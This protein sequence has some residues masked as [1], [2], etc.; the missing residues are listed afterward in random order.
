MILNKKGKE[1]TS[2]TFS[3]LGYPLD[4]HIHPYLILAIISAVAPSPRFEPDARSNFWLGLAI[5]LALL[6][7]AW[8]DWGMM[9][10]PL[11]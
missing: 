2:R 1:L 3:L 6:F 9:K 8:R 7:T 11:I 4:I 5:W 10:G